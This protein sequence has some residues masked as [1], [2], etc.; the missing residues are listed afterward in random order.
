MNLWRC[1]VTILAVAVVAGLGCRSQIVGLTAND[2]AALRHALDTEM[3]AAN[4][5]DAAAWASVYTQDAIAWSRRA[6]TSRAIVSPWHAA[7]AARWADRLN[8][9]IHDTG[10]TERACRRG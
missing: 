9:P 10:S 8:K 4:A 5:A 3:T 6:H 7:Q 1:L 2:E